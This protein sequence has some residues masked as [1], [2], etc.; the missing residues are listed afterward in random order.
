MSVSTLLGH[1]AIQYLQNACSKYTYA[2]NLTLILFCYFSG[3]IAERMNLRYF[4]AA[5]MLLSGFFTAAFGFGYFFN[6]HSLV[7]Y[8]GVQVKSL[9]I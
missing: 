1:V 8:V 7:F 5:G 2:K 9:W 3:H 4:L 6:I